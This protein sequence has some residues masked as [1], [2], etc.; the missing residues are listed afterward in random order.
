MGL[1]IGVLVVIIVVLLS[2]IFSV[3]NELKYI[4]SQIEENMGQY[5]NIRTKKSYKSVDRLA[6]SINSLYEENQRVNNKIKA[7]DEEL[8]RSVANMSHD[9]RTPLTSIMGYLQLIKDKKTTEEE[10]LE[11]LEIVEKRTKTL[12]EFITG[13]YDLSRIQ[14]SEYSFKLEKISIK[15]ILEEN[16][17][18]FYNDFIMQGIEPI[19]EIEEDIPK[20][21]S[22][23]AVMNR[24]FSNLMKNV[25]QHG[26]KDIKITMKNGEGCVI[27]EFSNYAPDITEEDAKKVFD[28]FFTHSKSRSEENTG[29]G[30][31]IVKS[32]V[33][34]LGNEIESM[35]IDNDFI[36]RIKWKA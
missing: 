7:A 21:I 8:K 14:G 35:K 19:I 31:S 24:I 22:D 4:R 10:R 16:I 28:R 15:S 27:T 29:L 32:F 6:H 13:F 3:F 30:L 17:A 33:E 34:E 12:K 9:L 23:K 20:I 11:F 25:L 18:Q 26:E 2:F 36:I 1:V 5:H